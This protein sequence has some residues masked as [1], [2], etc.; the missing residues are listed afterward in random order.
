MNYHSSNIC[1][2]ASFNS[3][4]ELIKWTGLSYK[5][6]SDLCGCSIK[7]VK[8]WEK[9]NNPPVSS[10]RLLEWYYAGIPQT[11]DLQG[12]KLRLGELHSPGGGVFS[13]R[14]LEILPTLITWYH[15]Q[16]TLLR[17]EK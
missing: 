17:G 1:F 13:I 15:E 3:F 9:Y 7:T 8:H 4:S 14:Q 11:N 16:K 6:I 2:D 10:R 12:W 5:D